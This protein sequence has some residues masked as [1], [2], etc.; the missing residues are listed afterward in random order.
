MLYW[1]TTYCLRYK[2]KAMNNYFPPKFMVFQYFQVMKSLLF[3]ESLYY[4]LI[5]YYFS[6][7]NKHNCLKIYFE[8]YTDTSGKRKT[9]KL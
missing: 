2:K 3:L 9:R 7:S 6:C 8:R 1:I 5:K 4:I